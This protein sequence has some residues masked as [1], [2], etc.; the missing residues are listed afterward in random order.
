M[1]VQPLAHQQQQPRQPQPHQPSAESQPHATNKPRPGRKLSS[2]RLEMLDDTGR[3]VFDNAQQQVNARH[4]IERQWVEDYQQYHGIYEPATQKRLRQTPDRASPFL[5]LTRVASN[6]V[7]SQLADML[8]P[9]DSKNWALGPTPDPDMLR[10]AE[11]KAPVEMANVQFIDPATGQPVTQA[12]VAQEALRIARTRAARMERVIEDQLVESRYNSE[13]RKA[14]HYACLLGTGVLCGPEPQAVTRYKWQPVVEPPESSHSHPDVTRTAIATE[15]SKQS[16][17]VRN[18]LPWDFFPDMSAATLSECEFIYERSYATRQQLRKLKQQP[19]FIPQ[20]I[21]KALALHPSST[22][23]VT[24]Q[25]TSLRQLAAEVSQRDTG[26]TVLLHQDRRYELWTYYG[27]VPREVFEALHMEL[28]P[29][30]ESSAA[31]QTHFDGVLV[32]VGPH[33]IKAVLNPLDTEEWPYSVFNLQSDDF[34]IFGEGIPRMGRNE[35]RVINSAWRMLLD[36]SGKAAGPQVV[37]KAGALTPAYEGDDYALTPWKLW[38]A[39]ETVT[40]VRSAFAVFTFPSLQTEITNILRMAQQF[41]TETI[42]LPPQIG[43]GSGQMPQTLGG[44]AML[45]NSVNS[46]RRRQVRDWDDNITTP[47]ITRFYHWNMQYHTDPEIKGDFEVRAR[48]TSALLL[49]EQ[50]ALNLMAMLDKYAGHPATANAMKPTEAL[51]KIAQAMHIPPEEIVRTEDELKA[52]AEQEQQ[53]QQA[54]PQQQQQADRAQEAQIKAEAQAMVEQIRS[55]QIRL[56]AE[57]QAQIEQQKAQYDLE[58]RERERQLRLALAQFDMQKHD[59]ALQLEALQYAQRNDLDYKK[60]LAD[61]KKHRW[62]LRQQADKFATE[63]ALKEVSGPQANYGL[64]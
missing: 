44:M 20:Q 19:H 12:E 40:D 23:T 6:L 34:C 30:D 2:R 11:N 22:H 41:L 18:V 45:M 51:R 15:H 14:L 4:N 3:S 49:R 52:M 7:E 24:A 25:T 27:P 16:P 64:E 42:G 36:N 38:F 31:P 8:F 53:Q 10:D 33:I 62:S 37:A 54:D 48:G 58:D 50:Q 21:D 28:P 32:L 55:D 47:L 61:L 46:D 63:V 43:E 35:Q 26:D 57:L 17:F 1:A 29:A 39:D 59:R 60:I 5:N 56:R 13:A 9:T